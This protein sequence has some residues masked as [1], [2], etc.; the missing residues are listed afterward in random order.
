MALIR[1]SGYID[2]PGESGR[3]R[4]I[5][6]NTSHI[7]FATPNMREPLNDSIVHMIDG[8]ALIVTMPFDDLWM[9]IQRET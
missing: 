4:D 1:V 7:M 3:E 9:L 6:I 5:I 8:E 2:I